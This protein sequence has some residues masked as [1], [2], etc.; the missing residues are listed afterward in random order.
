MSMVRTKQAEEES[1]MGPNGDHARAESSNKW[2]DFNDGLCCNPCTDV[3]VHQVFSSADAAVGMLTPISELTPET[4][5]GAINKSIPSNI[6]FV[7]EDDSFDEEYGSAYTHKSESSSFQDSTTL[8]SSTK[9]PSVS[10]Q[11]FGRIN[12]S[13]ASYYI[14]TPADGAKK[15]K[16]LA[17]KEVNVK[18]RANSGGDGEVELVYGSNA[19]LKKIGM[20]QSFMPFQRFRTLTRRASSFKPSIQLQGS[21]DSTKSL[22]SDELSNEEDDRPLVTVDC[23]Q[24]EN[25]KEESNETMAEKEW[26]D[27]VTKTDDDVAAQLHQKITAGLAE[28]LETGVFP[29]TSVESSV[30][31]DLYKDDTLEGSTE[32]L[33]K[34][35]STYVTVTPEEVCRVEPGKDRMTVAS[36]IEPG[37][38]RLMATY[39][40]PSIQLQGSGDSTKSLSSDE[41]SNEN[42]ERSVVIEHCIQYEDKK[43]ESNEKKVEKEEWKDKVETSAERNVVLDLQGD[44]S[45]EG[46]TEVLY[47]FGSTF[48]RVTPK[49]VCRIEPGKNRSTK[50]LPKRPELDTKEAE[51]VGKEANKKDEADATQ[52]QAAK[53]QSEKT[54]KHQ[55]RKVQS[56]HQKEEKAEAKRTKKETRKSKGTANKCAEDEAQETHEMK[57]NKN[58]RF[59][60]PLKF[61]YRR[62]NVNECTVQDEM[63]VQ[64]EVS[65]QEVW[66]TT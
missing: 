21:G 48:V 59:F 62:R 16:Q 43:E 25:K 1:T 3:D 23:I 57:S 6:I 51:K 2:L 37:K 56:K 63:S 61:L 45:L 18:E 15:K 52:E 50:V 65:V 44:D 27:E 24:Y 47:K 42:G 13:L 39:V 30:V 32:V 26:S 19:Y 5:M 12:S 58:S 35:G 40:T 20:R 9:Y 7:F 10:R 55:M 29:E 4:V 64:D 34:L 22:S 49:K 41:E 36:L 53:K 11:R 46:S 38:D 14:V 31:L 60:T 54:A 28:L 33:Y 66:R 8:G 17:I